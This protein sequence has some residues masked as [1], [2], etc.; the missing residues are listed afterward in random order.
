MLICSIIRYIKKNKCNLLINDKTKLCNKEKYW[1][2]IVR[3]INKN[4]AMNEIAKKNIAIFYHFIKNE[5]SDEILEP[6]IIQEGIE[7]IDNIIN[8]ADSIN[9]YL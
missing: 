6:F 7:R 1:E 8:S 3:D 5:D 4:F 2:T 9:K